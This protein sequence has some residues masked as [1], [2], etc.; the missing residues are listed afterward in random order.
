MSRT[1]KTKTRIKRPNE[2]TLRRWL[3]FGKQIEATAELP[4]VKKEEFR[5]DHTK[6]FVFSTLE[7]NINDDPFKPPDYIEEVSDRASYLRR[8]SDEYLAGMNGPPPVSP[9]EQTPPTHITDPRF[10]GPN[11]INN[12]IV[13]DAEH[14]LLFVWWA[15]V[16]AVMV[17]V[18]VLLGALYF[19][20]KLNWGHCPCLSHQAHLTQ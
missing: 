8:K 2:L 5:D 18:C 4:I 9:T 20:F 3:L 1:S 15:R 19:G 11:I 17:P 12:F 7:K 16:I 10:N 14:M 13:N 6:E